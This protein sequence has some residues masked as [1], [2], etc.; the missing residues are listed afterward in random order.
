LRVTAR[1][2]LAVSI[3]S[4]V[5]GCSSPDGPGS[6]KTKSLL[7]SPFD[8]S[9]LGINAFVNDARFG[10]IE[11]QFL[12][13]RDKLKIHMLRILM[14]WNDPVQPS[15]QSAIN[16]SFYDEI[17][18]NLPPGVE[19][20]VVLTGAPGWMD[21]P[22]NW[23]DGN[24]RASFVNRFASAVM[25]RYGSN[26]QIVGWEIWNEPDDSD[27]NDNATLDLSS[28]P[29]N[30]VQLMSIA[31]AASRQ[32]SPSKLV[33]S[34]ATTSITDDFPNKLVYNQA[35]RDG[36]M[37]SYIDVWG[38][39]FYGSEFDLFSS[40]GGPQDFLNQL[41]HP[42]WITESGKRGFTEQLNYAQNSWPALRALVPGIE[43]IYIYQ[44]TEN[45]S[46]GDTYGLRNLDG[47]AGH[48]DLYLF[49]RNESL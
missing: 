14:A 43:R 37:E 45:N 5:F 4:Q 42:I 21:D 34:G 25:Q 16:F 47:A 35:L 8:R 6:A 33:V 28:N 20:L 1:L 46:S 10:T 23:D 39:H 11:N 32:Y 41:Q 18:A 19:A 2:V 9:W 13:V 17:V 15:P 48:S 26:P 30:F 40:A 12:E 44:F 31:F 24:P 49:L 3:L 38:L 27:R 7:Q 22:K 36:G 29:Q